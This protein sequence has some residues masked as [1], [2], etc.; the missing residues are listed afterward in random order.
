MLKEERYQKG[1]GTVCY[2]PS[3]EKE[4]VNLYAKVSKKVKIML[5]KNK[6]CTALEPN[7][8]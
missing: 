4:A 3:T 6:W 1:S 5:I 2:D 8:K 7:S